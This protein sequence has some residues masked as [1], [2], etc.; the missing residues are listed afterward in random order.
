MF[1]VRPAEDASPVEGPGNDLFAETAIDDALKDQGVWLRSTN[2]SKNNSSSSSNNSNTKSSSN[3]SSS[4]NS[5]SNKQQQQQ[6]VVWRRLT[7][8]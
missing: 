4:R 8:S 5:S 1:N 7:K 6:Q 2:S 3:S